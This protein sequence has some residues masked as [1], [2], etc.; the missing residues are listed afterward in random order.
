MNKDIEA[1]FLDLGDT[2]RILVKDEAHQAKAK[3]KLVELAG[4][5]ESPDA[6]YSKLERRY[7]IYRDWAFEMMIEAS[8]VELWSRFMLADFP[9]DRIIPLASE[10]A[11]QFR[12]S[13]GLRV[14]VKDGKEV[15]YELERR[16]YVLGIISNLITVNEVP[17]WLE[18]EGLTKVF[19][20]VMLSSVY[21]KRKPHPDIYLEAARRAGVAPAKCVYVG[22]NF[23]RD[24]EGTYAAGFGGVVIMTSPE[25]QAKAQLTPLNTPDVVIHEFKQLLDIFPGTKGRG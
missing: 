24:V 6:F 3:A 21:G 22:D 16:G 7:S 1:I 9:Q 19:K 5:Q 8:E 13:K 11:I 20:S 2:V 14:M 18:A 10:F 17:E 15:I 25:K 4:T 23:D 12:Q